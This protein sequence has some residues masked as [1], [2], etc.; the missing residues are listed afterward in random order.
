[1]FSA[2]THVGRGGGGVCIICSVCQVVIV[3]CCFMHCFLSQKVFPILLFYFLR[4]LHTVQIR[5]R[6]EE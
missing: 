2:E 5:R 1:M 6:N 3:A 4:C